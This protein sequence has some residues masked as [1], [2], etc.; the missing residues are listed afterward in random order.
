V[1]ATPIELNSDVVVVVAVAGGVWL[2]ILAPNCLIMFNQT[3]KAQRHIL[4]SGFG[5]P[6]AS[7][8][9]SPISDTSTKS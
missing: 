9:H 3:Y 7:G 8:S 4:S 2:I 1:P 6:S 5:F